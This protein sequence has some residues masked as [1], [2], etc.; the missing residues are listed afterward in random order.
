MQPGLTPRRRSLSLHPH[1]PEEEGNGLA[2][3]LRW[4]L[5]GIIA[6][7]IVLTACGGSDDAAPATPAAPTEIPPTPGPP[8][9]PTVVPTPTATPRPLQPPPA[10]AVP[11]SPEARAAA[12]ALLT[13]V[14]E[15]RKSP[16]KGP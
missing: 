11:F 9:T 14:A 5:A 2:F 8:P 3:G 16:P 4:L 15:I 6:L 1:P 7:G 10:N 13:R 12:E